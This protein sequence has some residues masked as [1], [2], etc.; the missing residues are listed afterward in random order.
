MIKTRAP[1]GANKYENRIDSKPA[2]TA[3]RVCPRSVKGTWSLPIQRRGCK[4]PSRLCRLIARYGRPRVRVAD[5]LGGA[6]R[7]GSAWSQVVKVVGLD[8]NGLAGGFAVVD[9][10]VG[11]VVNAADDRRGGSGDLTH[12]GR[13]GALPEIWTLVGISKVDAIADDIRVSALPSE[14]ESD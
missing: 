13:E 3:T 7:P 9:C 6:L 1:D 4:Y 8:K 14:K 5:T 11:A 12:L 2:N 10:H